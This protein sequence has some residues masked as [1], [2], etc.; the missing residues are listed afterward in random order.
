MSKEISSLLHKT[1]LFAALT[2]FIPLASAQTA[3]TAQPG[4][5]LG[6][7]VNTPAITE[8]Q[9][10]F[11][12]DDGSADKDIGNSTQFLW[13]NRFTPD[14]ADFP[15]QI[16]EIQVLMGSLGVYI[17]DAVQILVYA[18][19]DGDGDP[20]TGAEFLGALDSTVQNTGSKDFNIYTL[21]E[22]IRVEGPGD[23]LIGMINRGSIGDGSDFPASLDST[24]SAGRSWMGTFQASDIPQQPELPTDDLWGTTDS[25]GFPGNWVI[26]AT[27]TRI[28]APLPPAAPVPILNT[29]GLIVLALLLVFGTLLRHA[30]TTNRSTELQ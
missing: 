20:G 24:V 8:G 18:D 28:F 13:F 5:V 4:V 9:I 30:R 6:H 11:A 27:G 25:F 21:P 10:T 15:F 7:D 29:L 22:P 14:P 26:R 23:I 17:G 3:V 19:T 2:S 1:L 12:I 16:E